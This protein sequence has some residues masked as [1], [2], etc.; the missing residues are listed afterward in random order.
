[1]RQE[2]LSLKSI[3]EFLEDGKLKDLQEMFKNTKMNTEEK[4]YTA[5]PILFKEVMQLDIAQPVLHN[6]RPDL[7]VHGTVLP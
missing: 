5:A 1:M 3:C 2:Q 4:V 6:L 7:P